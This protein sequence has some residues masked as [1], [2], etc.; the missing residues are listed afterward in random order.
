MSDIDESIRERSRGQ[1]VQ[2]LLEISEYQ[3]AWLM[4]KAK[5]LSDLELSEFDQGDL[6][7]EYWR[8]LRTIRDLQSE[9]EA[10]MRT[11]KVAAQKISL[12]QKA[13]NKVKTVMG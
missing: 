4:L 5:V 11:G 13:K 9:F 2:Q 10:V 8:K 12:M 7:D 6:R 1:V 3:N